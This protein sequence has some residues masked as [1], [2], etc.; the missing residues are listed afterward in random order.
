MCLGM[1]Q[2]LIIVGASFLR[3]V[4]LPQSEIRVTG[5]KFGMDNYS[6]FH[7][8]PIRR[9]LPKQ[10]VIAESRVRIAFG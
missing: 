8:K 5:D 3:I 4:F 10:A 2:D 1:L 9:K 7:Q 6:T